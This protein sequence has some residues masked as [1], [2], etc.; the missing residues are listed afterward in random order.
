MTQDFTND[1]RDLVVFL[2]PRE[3]LL[4]NG[5]DV[6]FTIAGDVIMGGGR[7]RRRAIPSEHSI[8]DWIRYILPN[9]YNGKLGERYRLSTPF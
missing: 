9:L 8:L 3:S 7:A 1:S 2:C 6:T 4:H 5:S